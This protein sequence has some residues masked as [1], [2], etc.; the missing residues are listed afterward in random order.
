[1]QPD[2]LPLV[3]QFLTPDLINKIADT[4]GLNRTLARTIITVAVP[5]LLGAV[6]GAAAQPGGAQKL[7]DAAKETG[8]FDNLS[9]LIAGGN[10]T[11]V[12]DKGS[13]LLSSVLGGQENAI[14][15]TLSNFGGVG[16]AAG[17]SVLGIA[18]PIVVGSLTNALGTSGLTA[19]NVAELAGA[20]S[21]HVAAPLHRDR[22]GSRRFGTGH[23]D[24]PRHEH[25]QKGQRGQRHRHGGTRKAACGAEGQCR[26]SAAFGLARPARCRARRHASLRCTARYGRPSHRC[27]RRRQSR[28]G[29]G[30]HDGAAHQAAGAAAAETAHA[31]GANATAAAS[32]ASRPLK[33]LGW[34]IPV[35]VLAALLWYLFGRPGEQAT[36]TTASAPANTPTSTA[37]TAPTS[38][39]VGTSTS[40]QANSS[41]PSSLQSLPRLTIGGPDVGKQVN[42]SLGSLRTSLQEGIKA[43]RMTAVGFGASDPIASNDTEEGRAKNRRIEITTKK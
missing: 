21:K 33:W 36:Q 6:T 16:E 39:P 22:A 27:R 26:C 28:S 9:N 12:A 30:D 13:Q 23:A 5:A 15:T 3:M 8:S 10:M 40:T 1:M 24:A 31:A 35:I 25:D 43:D 20:Q 29:S 42:D 32:A 17:K 7:A 2:L 19:A 11:A 4:L 34:A 18:A 38:P 37:P 41:V 14:A